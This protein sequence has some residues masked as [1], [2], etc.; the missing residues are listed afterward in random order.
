MSKS[1]NVVI[2]AEAAVEYGFKDSNGKQPPSLE[3]QKGSPCTF[4]R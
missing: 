4:F 1:G 3:E 2:A